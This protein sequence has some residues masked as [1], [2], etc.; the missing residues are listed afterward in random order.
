MK[1]KSAA[2]YQY[3]W[4]AISEIYLP[5]ENDSGDLL[6]N[7]PPQLACQTMNMEMTTAVCG[8]GLGG[9]ENTSVMSHITAIV[10]VT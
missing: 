2:D 5:V 3:G 10:N 9:P 4:A 1:E 7:S 6:G 8:C